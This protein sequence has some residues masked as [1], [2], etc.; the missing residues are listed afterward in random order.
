MNKISELRQRIKSD[1]EV[2][3]TIDDFNQ[4]Q[5]EWITRTKLDIGVNQLKADA[6][7]EMLDSMPSLGFDSDRERNNWIGDYI[8]NL[9]ESNNELKNDSSKLLS[10]IDDLNIKLKKEM[11]RNAYISC[12]GK[13]IKDIAFD[14]IN[15]MIFQIGTDATGSNKK[16]LNVSAIEKYADSL[17]KE[18]L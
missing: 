14:A 18:E 5:S 6:I 11:S 4:L 17:I 13:S 9:N 16:S 10:K 2:V 15:E 12:T 7:S 3:I 8:H 1:N